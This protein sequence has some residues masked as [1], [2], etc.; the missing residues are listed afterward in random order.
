MRQDEPTKLMPNLLTVAV[1]TAVATAGGLVKIPSPVGSVAVD[2]A[3][4][5]FCSAFYGPWVGGIVGA[6]GHL[7]SAASGGF[8]LGLLHFVVAFEMFAFTFIFGWLARRWSTSTGL[9]MAS[10]AAIA[11]NGLAAS[12]I[13]ALVPSI[14]IPWSLARTLIPFL[15]AAS[16]ANVVLAAGA[17]RLLAR[18][19]VPGI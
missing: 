18:L 8:P 7:G 12:P 16:F 15:L 17:F 10:A 14:G 6:L 1:F 19:R 2:S 13:L 5:Y 9:A 4:G 3:P 11:L